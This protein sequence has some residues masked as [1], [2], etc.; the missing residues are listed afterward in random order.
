MDKNIN[1]VEGLPHSI[2]DELS[3][4]PDKIHLGILDNVILDSGL[5]LY[6]ESSS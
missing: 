6:P 1:F 4:P 5:N 3:S 2:E